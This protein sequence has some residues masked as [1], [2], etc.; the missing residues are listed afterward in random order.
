ME[1]L[2]LK[3]VTA[4]PKSQQVA[5]FI[6]DQIHNGEIKPG[7]RLAS[8]RVLA[9]KFGVGRQVVLSAF[10]ILTKEKLV[11]S[12]VGRGTFVSGKTASVRPGRNYRM[13]F[14]INR[15][16]VETFYNRNLFLGVSEK[17]GEAG[18]TML[19]APDDDGFDLKSWVMRKELDVLLVSGRVDGDFLKILEELAVPFVVMGKYYLPPDIN[20]IEPCEEGVTPK[21]IRRV[22]NKFRFKSMGAVLGSSDLRVTQDLISI[23]KKCAREF[24][25]SCGD[26]YINC[27]DE[28]EGYLQARDIYSGD[29]HPEA[30]FVTGQAFPGVARYLFERA[31]DKDFE[32]PVV[33][34]AAT[35]KYNIMYPELVN[36]VIYTSGRETGNIAIEEAIKLLNGEIKR[37]SYQVQA[38]EF[39]LLN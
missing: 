39:E 6:R 31:G 4:P 11:F 38:S 25:V 14:Y 37:I 1:V 33:I 5:D 21:A 18:V 15:S 34:T 35:D 9:G 16:R 2:Q 10:E 8:V 12:H 26:K 36:A 3:L 30:L 23:I 28:E 7:E 22:W 24:P 29:E 27:S 13:G 19:L 17:A 32:K 20:I